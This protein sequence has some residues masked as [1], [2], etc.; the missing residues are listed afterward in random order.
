MRSRLDVVIVNYHSLRPLRE[1]LPSLMPFLDGCGD[2]VLV[3]NSP[4]DGTAHEMQTRWPSLTVVQSPGNI[5]FARAVNCGVRRGSAD[6]ILLVNP[7]IRVS[8][9]TVDGLLAPFS[10]RRVA[11]VGVKTLNP[12]GSIQRSCKRKPTPFDL[13]DNNLALTARFPIVAARQGAGEAS[14]E[15]ECDEVVDVVSGAFVCLRRSIWDKVGPFDERYFV[16]YEET[17]WMVRAKEMGLGTVYNPR[18]VVMHAAG[19]SSEESEDELT[20]LL[21][22]SQQKYVRKHYGWLWDIA[23]RCVFA[24]A[25]AAR[26]VRSWG[27][28]H[29][30]AHARRRVWARMRVFLA[31]SARSRA[32]R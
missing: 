2:V 7:D 9:G 20:L 27:S 26:W 18:V 28:P 16:Y 24:M 15:P 30:G 3:D 12:D 29:E 25:E 1:C 21:W 31:G 13:L 5:G 22:E 19:Q 23:L 4:G 6:F 8:D 14:R 11:A 10:D 32:S 17:D